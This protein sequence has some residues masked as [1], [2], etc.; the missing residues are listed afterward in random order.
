MFIF[1]MNLWRV[2]KQCN[3][4]K[5]WKRDYI[6]GVNHLS[7][8]VFSLFFSYWSQRSI[9]LIHLFWTKQHS[10]P[11]CSFIAFKC[12]LQCHC[13]WHI[14]NRTDKTETEKETHKRPG[15]VTVSGNRRVRSW[16]NNIAM[17]PLNQSEWK[18]VFSYPSWLLKNIFLP[19]IR[20]GYAAAA[21]KIY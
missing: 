14:K 7:S 21:K 13:K 11:S 2:V 3:R 18:L 4:A 10:N 1:N 8:S 19:N 17:F 20:L 5:G 12:K 16:L 9:K 6:F 15:R